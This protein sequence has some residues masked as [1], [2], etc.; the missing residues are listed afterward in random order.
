MHR[1]RQGLVFAAVTVLAAAATSSAE[2]QWGDIKGRVVLD[3]AVP[4]VQLL[5]KKGDAS[6]KDAAV[7]AAEDIPSEEV[8]VDPTSKGIANVAVYLRRKPSKI[9]P[10]LEPAA[11]VDVVYDQK[12][13]RFIPHMAVIQAGQK[14]R[15]LN[16]D[17]VAHNTRGNPVR[18]QGFNFIV[19]PNDRMGVK[20]PMRAGESVPVQVG[21]DIHPWMRGWWLVVDHPYA[22]VTGEDGSFTIKGLPP[23]EHE[24]RVW[25]EKV[26]YL[27]KSLK[28]TVKAGEETEIADIKVPAKTLFE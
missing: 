3:G 26:G 16:D 14:V 25:Q 20:V 1:Y 18:N 7:C 4:A 12:G 23:G 9:N 27:E 19:A 21:C 8:V 15:V 5:I 10:E 2:A 22:A 24:F 17:A 28:V 13:C 11:D 6:A